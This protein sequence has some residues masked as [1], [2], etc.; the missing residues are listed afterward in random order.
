MKVYVKYSIAIALWIL[1]INQPR[2]NYI[3]IAMHTKIIMQL[4][5]SENY[6][7]MKHNNSTIK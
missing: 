5:I 3:A 1:T 2:Y 7:T 4:Y 6:C